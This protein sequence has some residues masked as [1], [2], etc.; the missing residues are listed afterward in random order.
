[1]AWRVRAAFEWLAGVQNGSECTATGATCGAGDCGLGWPR[2][3][4]LMWV[5]KWRAQES[6]RWGKGPEWGGWE[7]IDMARCFAAVGGTIGPMNSHVP[8]VPVL[9][10]REGTGLAGN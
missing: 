8:A 1:M 3:G 7:G 5:R 4:A 9:E 6:A 2:T 10:Q